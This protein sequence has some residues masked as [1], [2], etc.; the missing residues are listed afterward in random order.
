[1]RPDSSNGLS[2]NLKA[3]PWIWVVVFYT[4]FVTVM[5]SFVVIAVK[6]REPSVPLQ[7]HGR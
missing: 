1:M 2:S 5:I 3:R 4:V 6:H 7:I